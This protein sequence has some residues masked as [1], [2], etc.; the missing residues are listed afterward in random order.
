LHASLAEAIG[1]KIKYMPEWKAFGWYTTEDRAEWNV[2]IDK[3]GKYD[4]Y[5]EWS[6]ADSEGGKSFV[7]EAG[8]KKIKGK[9]GKTGSWFT[10]RTEKIGTVNLSAGTQKFVLKSNSKSEKGAM[11][12]LREIKLIPAK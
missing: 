6:V 3:A 2:Q 9:A 10:Y 4:V 5:M 11:F 7:L 8:K 12:D 1:P